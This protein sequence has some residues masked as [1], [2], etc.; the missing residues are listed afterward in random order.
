MGADER[1]SNNQHALQLTV[2]EAVDLVVNAPTAASVNINQTATFTGILEN[3]S[4]ADA[5]DVTLSIAVHPGLRADTATWSIG[6]CTVTPQQIDCTADV[7]PARSTSDLNITATALSGGTKDVTVV[8]TSSEADSVP[9]NNTVV[10]EVVVIDPNK[11]SGGSS[12]GGMMNPFMILLGLLA[13]RRTRK[14][15]IY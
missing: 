6:T 9:A 5:T 3:N 10:G 12:G 2:E 8:L 14:R 13:I 7:F 15:P 11:K 1:P 4:D